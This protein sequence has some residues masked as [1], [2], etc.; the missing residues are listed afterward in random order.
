METPFHNLMD[1]GLISQPE[2]AFYLGN[3]ANGE[4]T[5]GTSVLDSG[6]QFLLRWRPAHP[7]GL[8]MQLAPSDSATPTPT[9]T[10]FPTPK[11]GPARPTTRHYT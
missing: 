11:V 3:N 7:R 5:I 1:Q 9:L 10:P 8:P 4:L 2:F 6:S